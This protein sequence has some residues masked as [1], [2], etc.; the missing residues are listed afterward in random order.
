MTD[1][2]TSTPVLYSRETEEALLGAVL[3]NPDSYHTV[4]ARLRAEDFFILRHHY[5][6]EVFTQLVNNHVPLDF[7]TVTQALEQKGRLEEV[8]GPAY[9][10]GLINTVPTALHA[11]AYARVIAEHAGR[12]RL[13]ESANQVARLAYQTDIPFESALSEAE[14]SIFSV[15]Q[16][17]LGGNLRRLADVVGDARAL[18]SKLAE[19]PEE[20][21]GIPTGF[22]DLDKLLIGLQPSDL[23]LAAGRPG[24]GNTSL[25]LSLLYTASQ[26]HRK[27]V[28]MFTLEM[29]DEQLVQRLISQA[30]GIDGQLLR[31][32]RMTTN[33]WAL[34]NTTAD[35]LS[36]LPVFLDDT[37][38]ITPFQLRS[39]CRRLAMEHG[40]DLV[41]V[42]Y[43]QLM[44]GGS[45]A[46]EQR[47]ENRVQE[48]GHISRQLKI[49][50]KELNVPVVAAAQLSRAVEQRADKKPTLSDLRESG[51]LEM[52]A[53]VV[54]LLHRP[55]AGL[56]IISLEVAKHRKGPVG[57]VDLIYR[58]ELTRFENAHVV[59]LNREAA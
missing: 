53:D 40:L 50:A 56:N 37:P 6:W 54:I 3:I 21:L 35:A 4:A 44:A 22:I 24:M 46:K 47:F 38:A 2:A 55:T 34:F 1:A 48:V 59:D 33:D 52:D 8:G 58:P 27:R 31:S 17:L 12:R 36:A 29:S 18:A 39:A 9:L 49:L 51:N 5:V 30:G 57:T 42:D 26:V 43:L 15:G 45:G 10:T 16:Q 28:A 13:L 11:E 25:L 32:G 7:L 14:K 19:H 41:I 20:M 23:V